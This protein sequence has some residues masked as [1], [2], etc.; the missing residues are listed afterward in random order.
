MIKKTGYGS[1]SILFFILA[2]LS[3]I[4]VARTFCLGDVL[5][6]AFGIPTWT[7]GDHLGFHNTVFLTLGFLIAGLVIG[8]TFDKDWGARNGWKLCAFLLIIFGL[9]FIIFFPIVKSMS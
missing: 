6:K 2:I 7:N 4:K 8:K 9:A 1:L 3:S 5:L